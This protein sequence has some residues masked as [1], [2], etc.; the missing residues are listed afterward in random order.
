[1]SYRHRARG[2]PRPT[3]RRYRVLALVPPGAAEGAVDRD[4]WLRE[5]CVALAADPELS[6]RHRMELAAD[7][8][9]LHEHADEAGRVL[10]DPELDRITARKYAVLDVVLPLLAG[11]PD[12]EQAR[13]AAAFLGLPWPEPTR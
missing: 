1:M 13:Q 4:V 9:A 12:D 6:V 10:E 7:A 8:A 5:I 2:G 3:G 11:L